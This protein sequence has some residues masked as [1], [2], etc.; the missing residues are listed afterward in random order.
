MAT[1]FTKNGQATKLPATL[2]HKK[3]LMVIDFGLYKFQNFK[4]AYKISMATF[5]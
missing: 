2:G 4:L 1:R 5:A 3:K